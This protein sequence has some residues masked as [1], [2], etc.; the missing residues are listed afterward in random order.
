MV[1]KA[2]VARKNRKR[3]KRV[4]KKVND[5]LGADN[6]GTLGGEDGKNSKFSVEVKGLKKFVGEKY[7]LQAENNNVRKVIPIVVV[8]IVG[9]KYENDLVMIRFKDFKKLVKI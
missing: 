3:G 9:S 1:D 2:E 5:R 6:V 7:M 8:H 4:Q